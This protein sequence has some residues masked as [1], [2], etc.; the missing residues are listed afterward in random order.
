[1]P[2]PNEFLAELVT[3]NGIVTGGRFQA[4]AAEDLPRPGPPLLPGQY[5][6]ATVTVDQWGRVTNASAGTAS[7]TGGEG[8]VVFL[9]A[10]GNLSTTPAFHWSNFNVSGPLGT[11]ATLYV[12][13]GSDNSSVAFYD[14]VNAA[15]F[16][17]TAGSNTLDLSAGYVHFADN[18]KLRGSNRL[19]SGAA[20][21]AVANTFTAAPQTITIDAAGHIGLAIGAASGQT[22]DVIRLTEFGTGTVLFAVVANGGAYFANNCFLQNSRALSWNSTATFNGGCNLAGASDNTITATVSGFYISHNS[23]S[24]NPLDIR[25]FG[26]SS[27]TSTVY[28]AIVIHPQSAG[29]P[30]TGFGSQIKFQAQSSTTNARNQGLVT[31]TWASA[32]DASRKGQVSLWAYD[33][34]AAREG[35]RVETDG[36]NALIGFLGTAAVAQQ[37]SGANLTNNVTSGGTNDTIADFTDLVIYANDAATI[38]NDIYQLAR[39]LKQVNDALRLFGLLT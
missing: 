36:S 11:T 32:T 7:L 4:I 17:L 13:N 6:L 3:D 24:F 8:A 10:A 5:A 18:F 37:T 27:G 34:T 29:T 30:G 12:S 35:L 26:S 23:N 33:A 2:T 9:D 25:P 16:A 31:S 28:D 15:Y 39:K 14:A 19:L 38:R 21:T 20:F 22:A 1:M